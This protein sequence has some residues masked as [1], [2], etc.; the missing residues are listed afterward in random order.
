MLVRESSID[1]QQLTDQHHH[2]STTRKHSRECKPPPGPHLEFCH[3][4]VNSGSL[5]SVG[6]PNL[7]TLSQSVAELLPF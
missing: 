5:I 4:I 6:L 3:E 7:V 1:Y 2:N